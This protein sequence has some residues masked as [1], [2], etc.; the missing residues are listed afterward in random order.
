MVGD[1]LARFTAGLLIGLLGWAGMFWVHSAL[2]LV[3]GLLI[4][5]RLRQSPDQ[6]DET[7]PSLDDYAE[8]TDQ[9]EAG[10]DDDRHVSIGEQLRAM[11]KTRDSTSNG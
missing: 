4:W 10:G 2:L 7:L 8:A 11:F 9:L 6:V 5:T 3:I 1:A